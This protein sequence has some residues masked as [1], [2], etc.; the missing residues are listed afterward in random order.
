MTQRILDRMLVAGRHWRRSLGL[1]ALV[2]GVVGPPVVELHG[3]APNAEREEAA[4]LVREALHGEAY[5]L[6]ARRNDLLSSAAAK[7]PGYGP[8]YWQRGWLRDG[9]QWK[10][11]QDTLADSEPSALQQEYETRRTAVRDNVNDHWQLANWCRE[12]RLEAQ[13][14]AHLEH[15]LDL[16][17]DHAPARARLGYVSVRGEWVLETDRRAAAESLRRA[18]EAMAEYRGELRD[19]ARGLAS[20]APAQRQTARD[21]L[22]KITDLDAIPALESQL[23]VATQEGGL[24]VVG[25]LTT[26]RDQ[27]AVDSLV[28]HAIYSTWPSV[29]EAAAE[30]LRDRSRER[31][32]PGM[33]AQ[34]YTAAVSRFQ[35]NGTPRGTLAYRHVAQREGREEVQSMV[36]DTEYFREFRFNSDVRDTL[37]RA[38]VDS[39]RGIETRE[40]QLA[41]GN[42]RQSTLN[43]RLAAALNIATNQQLPAVPQTWWQWWDQQNDMGRQGQKPTRQM[44][45][46]QQVSVQDRPLFPAP[47]QL[48]PVQQVTQPPRRH[49]CFAAGTPVVTRFGERPIEKIQVGDLVLAKDIETGELAF[50]PVVRTTV[51]PPEK[52][53]RI[54]IGSDQFET[55]QGHLFWQCGKGW[56]QARELQTGVPLHCL[57]GPE[58]INLIE[59][60]PEV[61]TY[62]LVVADFHTYFVGEGRVLSHDVTER[63]ATHAV[64]PGL[65]IND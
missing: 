27:A 34:M 19:I 33:V 9:D 35:V 7:D 17:R 18:T 49:E 21:R 65:T 39:L 38:F 56:S 63:R 42:L 41:Q 40:A 22:A 28:R 31:Y 1:M 57:A 53:V 37:R 6:S 44:S 5:G 64:V 43:Q 20:E 46:Y 25:H 62:N 58:S 36:L 16:N 60:G 51:R 47:V 26:L 50:K 3:A 30:A 61:E 4:G 45:G 13:E 15:I 8:A 24:A 48:I 23:S 55:S 2:A 54:R 11:L 14:R 59:E 12:R 32:V 52:T 10:S 29:R